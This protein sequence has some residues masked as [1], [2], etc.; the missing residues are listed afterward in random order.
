VAGGRL[1][2][3]AWWVGLGLILAAFGGLLVAYQQD[4][5]PIDGADESEHLESCRRLAHGGGLGE[6]LHDPYEFVG[7]NAIEGIDGAYYGK[8][9]FGW[10][11]LCA[12]A[13]RVAGPSA[14]FWLSPLFALLG[15]AGIGLFGRALAGPVA[16]LLAA[17]LLATNPLYAGYGLTVM[18][19]SAAIVLSVFGL[20]AAWRLAAGGGAGAAVAA[21]LLC[22]AAALTRYGSALVAVALLAAVALRLARAARAGSL[23]RAARDVALALAAAGLVLLPLLL[24]NL[25]AFGSPFETGQGITESSGVS[26]RYW[27]R[28]TSML[29]GELWASGLWVAVSAG[30]LGWIALARRQRGLALFLLA[31]GGGHFA[32]Y[33]S[34]Y[35]RSGIA[36]WPADLRYY[37]D[38]FPPLALAAAAGVASSS[39]RA[40]SLLIVLCVAALPLGALRSVELVKLSHVSNQAAD[41]IGSVVASTVPA[42]S[43]IFT[44]EDVLHALPWYGDWLLYQDP[45][46][47]PSFVA[48]YEW[49][50]HDERPWPVSR[51]RVERWNALLGGRTAARLAEDERR[52]AGGLLAEGRRVFFLTGGNYAPEWRE[53]LSPAFR[54][55]RH[56]DRRLD[57]DESDRRFPS[58]HLQ[59]YEL[60]PLR[61][62]A[63]VR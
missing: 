26:P 41:R 12:A 39:G 50:L 49:L 20:W 28:N 11:I 14:P 61:G 23:P 42:G 56:V 60:F 38:V 19:H 35:W 9:P 36:Q 48:S 10:S 21:G 3:I 47:H 1:D 6:T 7:L 34:F 29:V 62:T 58:R 46:F 59:I 52:L 2:G 31:W 8:H 17:A 18:T 55:E 22:G 40:R 13:L 5:F 37:L 33:H 24:H 27:L 45:M 32:L 44:D 43:A 25:A 63:G 16:G 30:V 4:G 57:W 54:I 51:R 15:V 53:R